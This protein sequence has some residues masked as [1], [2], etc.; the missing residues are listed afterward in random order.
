MARLA[1]W[2]LP[3]PPNLPKVDL[4]LAYNCTTCS[5]GDR[6]LPPPPKRHHHQ[7]KKPC[8]NEHARH[9]SQHAITYSMPSLTVARAGL[10]RRTGG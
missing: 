9:H 6:L 10:A 1:S 3:P 4:W 8:A 7:S 5:S 2:V